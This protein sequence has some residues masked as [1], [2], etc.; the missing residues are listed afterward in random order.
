MYSRGAA[1]RITATEWRRI[2]ELVDARRAASRDAHP[3]DSWRS[4]AQRGPAENARITAG[5]SAL[6]AAE[7]QLRDI[8]NAALIGPT[9]AGEQLE[10]FADLPAN[11]TA[12]TALERR[13][14]PD[15]GSAGALAGVGV[16]AYGAHRTNGD[17]RP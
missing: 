5:W 17:S 1:G 9:R 6:H 8:I 2:D 3:V 10:L 12:T 13:R 11:L 4:P 16:L 7:C 15:D 14:R